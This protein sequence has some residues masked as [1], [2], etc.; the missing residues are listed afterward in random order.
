MSFTNPAAEHIQSVDHTWIPVQR[1]QQLG[2]RHP[3]HVKFVFKEEGNGEG[4]CSHHPS[5]LSREIASEESES[6]FSR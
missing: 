2:F 5:R 1:Q 6:C 4:L 3:R